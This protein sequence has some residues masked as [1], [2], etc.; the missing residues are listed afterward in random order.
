MVGPS[1]TFFSNFFIF[2]G[3]KGETSEP[4]HTTVRCNETLEAEKEKNGGSQVGKPR[5]KKPKT[6]QDE[7]QLTALIQLW[8]HK[9]RNPI[10]DKHNQK[11]S[12]RQ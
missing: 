4:I 3:G 5:S 9:T 10:I 11:P 6:V 8:F 7:N 1:Y 12:L 2:F